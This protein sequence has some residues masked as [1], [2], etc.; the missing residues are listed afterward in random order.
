MLTRRKKYLGAVAL[1]CLVLT[2]ALYGYL[3]FSEGKVAA[4]HMFFK[5][6]KNSPLVIAHRGG[7]GLWAENTMYAFQQAQLLG[8]DIIEMDVRSTQDGV[9]VIIHDPTVE[10]TTNGAGRVGDMTLAEL[11]KLDAGYRWS[12]DGGNTFPLRQMDIT[13]PTVQ[14]VFKA[15]PEMRFNIEPKQDSPAIVQPLCRIIR[16]Q[17]MTDK[18]MIA[19]FSSA[20]LD[21]FRRA[22]PEIATSAS[23]GEVSTFLALY[24]TGLAHSYSPTMQALQ[25]PEYAGGIHVLTEDFVKAAHERNLEV[26]AWTVNEEQDMRR[27]LGIGLDGI[28]TD[29]PDRLMVSLGRARAP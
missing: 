2:G 21:D 8:V 5:S 7:A 29:Y 19:S 16:E 25:V 11:K 17:A 18:V 22:C 12:P 3:A 23:P 4:V 28:M 13:V 27:L 9:L 1:V 15:L 6:Q 26:H 20:I 14:E 24:K 10:R